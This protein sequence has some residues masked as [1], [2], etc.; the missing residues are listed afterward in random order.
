MM[1]CGNPLASGTITTLL[2]HSS[3]PGP[4]YAEEVTLTSGALG[5]YFCLSIIISA[6]MSFLLSLLCQYFH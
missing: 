1:F 3:M 2:R 6:L 5:P 4:W